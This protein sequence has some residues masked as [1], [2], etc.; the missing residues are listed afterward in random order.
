LLKD[1]ATRCVLRP[2]DGSKFVYSPALDPWAL[3]E[4]TEL[5]SAPVA[6]FGEG[7]GEGE[8]K[9]ARGGKGMEG[10]GNSISGLVSV[11]VAIV[12][13]HFYRCHHNHTT[14][15]EY[16]HPSISILSVIVTE[17]YV[18]GFGGHIAIFRCWLH[19]PGLLV[20]PGQW[21]QCH[22]LELAVIEYLTFSV[23]ISIGLYHDCHSSCDKT[24]SGFSCS[25]SVFLTISA[26]D[27]IVYQSP[28]YSFFKL[29]VSKNPI[30]LFCEISILS[31][32]FDFQRYQHL[33]FPV[34]TAIYRLTESHFRETSFELAVVENFVFTAENTIS[35]KANQ[36][37]LINMC[38]KLLFKK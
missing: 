4:L 3:G 21:T 24:I 32:I 23:E 13:I 9:T 1:A 6:A 22:I 33:A 30:R 14:H 35:F 34:S 20:T 38:V 37:L 26:V 12:S 17:I 18:Y 19:S 31:D 28:A 10:E 8:W 5:H 16:I 29:A 7:N 15:T 27:R 36:P 2:V 25:I 11:I